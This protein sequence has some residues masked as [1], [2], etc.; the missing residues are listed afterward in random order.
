MQQRGF[1]SIVLTPD[2]PQ[3]QDDAFPYSVLRYPS[4]DL[5]D[6]TGYM[7]GIPFSPELMR[8]LEGRNISLLH[9]HCPVV[10]TLLSRELRQVLD[11]PLVLTYHTKFDIDIAN[12]LQ[13]KT[14]RAGAIRALL[15]NINACDEIW[16]VSQGAG[17]N[18]R[19]L[20]YTGDC[21]LM[22]NGVDLPRARLPEEQVQAATGGYDLP[23][24]VP[25]YLFVG[26]IM[27]Y[28]GLRMILDAMA[29]LKASGKNFRMVL[30]GSGADFEEVSAYVHTL[31]LDDRVIFT[32]AVHE[33][34]TLRAWYCRSDLFLFPSTFDTNGLVVRE[35]AACSLASVLI[36]G[37]CA[38]EGVT[39]GTNGFLI[40]ENADS[41]F[42]CLQMLTRETA[43]QVGENAARDLY[44]SWEDAVGEAMARYEIIL[45]KYR[46]G[47]YDL[48]RK[49]MEPV[50]RLNGEL[51]EDLARLADTRQSVHSQLSD[52]LSE[53]RE[54]IRDILDLH[55][56]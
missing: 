47:G 25:V 45:E 5:R 40:E 29:K 34:E 10:S 3:A 23:E 15:A 33:R 52:L 54:H 37:S 38:A 18:L 17:E 16:V 7:A 36:D 49:H 19:S 1:D 53:H 43:R 2:H 26:R 14:L 4:L 44:L 55:H 56:K 20:G 41:L 31:G 28:K 12:I 24:G 48:P 50:F 9:S 51:M 35:A 6:K 42:A 21:V 39:H 46:S 11:V 27:W 32:G 13:S 30:V 22:H 8:Q